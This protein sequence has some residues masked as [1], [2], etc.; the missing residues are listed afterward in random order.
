MGVCVGKIALYSFAFRTHF[1]TTAQNNNLLL[2]GKLWRIFISCCFGLRG[3]PMVTKSIRV[4]TYW[5]NNQ[6]MSC[7]TRQTHEPHCQI[8]VYSCTCFQI[9]CIPQDRKSLLLSMSVGLKS[10]C[11]I[12]SAYLLLISFL[13]LVCIIALKPLTWGARMQPL[14][15][16]NENKSERGSGKPQQTQSLSMHAQ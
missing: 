9:S 2:C 14:G 1:C 12:M 6:K 3:S 11:F 16:K 4:E 5:H 7:R 15:N 13:C 10:Q 8:S